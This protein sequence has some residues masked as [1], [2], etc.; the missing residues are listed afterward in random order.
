MWP[1][2][3][4]ELMPWVASTIRP[5][6]VWV[7]PSVY[8]TCF[9]CCTKLQRRHTHHCRLCGQMFCSLCTGKWHLPEEYRK[10]GKTGPVR[11]C[12]GC[13]GACLSQR[14]KYIRASKPRRAGH[15]TSIRD[16]VLYIHPPIWSLPRKNNLCTM[17][18]RPCGKGHNCRVC[19]EIVCGLGCT[20]RMEVPH[21]FRKKGKMGPVRVCNECRWDM[22]AGAVLDETSYPMTADPSEQNSMSDLHVCDESSSVMVLRDVPAR[23]A[24]GSTSSES[25]SISYSST[26]GSQRHE[27]PQPPLQSSNDADLGTSLAMALKQTQLD[28]PDVLE[29]EPASQSLR[30]PSRRSEALNPEENPSA[31]PNRNSVTSPMSKLVRLSIQWMGSGD[32]LAVL[33]VDE[34]TPLDEIHELVL[35]QVEELRDVSFTYIC[36]GKLVLPD[37]WD[38]FTARILRPVLYIVPGTGS[39]VSGVEQPEEVEEH[40]E[41]HQVETNLNGDVPQPTSNSGGGEA[42]GPQSTSSDIPSNKPVVAVVVAKFALSLSRPNFLSFSKGDWIDVLVRKPNAKWWYGRLRDSPES[43]GWIPSNYV[44]VI[45]E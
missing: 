45:E 22:T 35:E 15:R 14:A 27:I 3:Q 17:C 13:R 28:Q 5:G 8:D 24:S 40:S 26:M 32:G 23:K 9:H 33:K 44:Q 30:T 2:R 16:G 41:E 1:D 31:L 25:E 39:N 37:F 4:K 34:D 43:S 42:I 20:T 36:R 19:G 18:T 21:A 6:V 12:F 11:V 29:V 7:D 38:L 10:K